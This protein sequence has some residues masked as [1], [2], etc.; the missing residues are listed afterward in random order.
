[1][2]ICAMQTHSTLEHGTGHEAPLL[3]T[4]LGLFDSEPWRGKSV[5]LR[6]VTQCKLPMLQQMSPIPLHKWA[7]GAVL[8][9]LSKLKKKCENKKQIQKEL[10]WRVNG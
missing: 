1:M 8:L 2:V 10:E 6:D 5:F 9:G 3:T 7:S 4:E